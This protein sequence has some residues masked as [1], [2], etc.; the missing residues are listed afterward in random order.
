MNQKLNNKT[1]CLFPFADDLFP[2]FMFLFHQDEL[3]QVGFDDECD[4]DE[5]SESD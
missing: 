5:D 3:G 4:H 2:F 1:G